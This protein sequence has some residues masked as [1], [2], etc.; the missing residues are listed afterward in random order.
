MACITTFAA[1]E[2]P[3]HSRKT[4]SPALKVTLSGDAPSKSASATSEGALLADGWRLR[5]LNVPMCVFMGAVHGMAVYALAK[6][7]CQWDPIGSLAAGGPTEAVKG[8]TLLLA[9]LLW[10]ICGLGITAGAHRLWA[11]KSYQAHWTVRLFFMLC[12]SV[13][14]QGPIYHWARDHRTHHLHSDTPLDPHDATIGWFY[15]HVG[16]LLVK[17]DPRVVAAG[18][19]I[20][21]S[22]LK[23]D[24]I[25]MFQKRWD[26]WWNF[27]FC[28]A[29]P[30]FM[31]M[32]LFKETFWNG[33]LVTGVLRW[34]WVLHCTWSVNSIVHTY[35]P[36]PYN[37]K[38]SP[39]ESRLVAFLAIGEGWH[40]WHHA[41]AFDY[42][43]SELGCWQQYNPTKLFID[44]LAALGLVTDRKRGHRMWEERKNR[45]RAQGWSIKETLSG[46]P[47]F[48]IRGLSFE[49]VRAH[50]QQPSDGGASGLAATGMSREKEE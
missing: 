23:A 1:T 39:S 42:A 21:I 14:S 41:F 26:P 31:A 17:I 9:V 16:W 11:H 44:I 37:P 29:V 12:N 49:R 45:W 6:V 40:S 19:K 25:V 15:S 35:G 24:K 4:S 8:Q 38:E 43:T 48:K 22:D 47:L 36:S 34:V 7:V 18:R 50:A 13:A 28:F 2:S 32:Y 46:P 20:D 5:Q 33:F 10:P 3:V 30:A 27:F